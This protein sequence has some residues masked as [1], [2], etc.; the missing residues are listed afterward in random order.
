MRVV[1]GTYTGDG[2]DNKAITGVGF[3]PDLVIVKGVA[4]GNAYFKITQHGTNESILIRGDTSVFTDGIKTLTSDGFTVGLSTVINAS[5]ATYHY[6]AVK[7]DGNGDFK[8]GTYIGN[9]LDGKTVT[10]L[11]FSPAFVLVKSNS[12][13]VGAMKFSGQVNSG[14]QFNGADRSDLIVSLDADGFTVND[15]SGSGANLVNVNAVP[16][17]WFAFKAVAGGC[18]VF[19]YTGDGLD[20]RSITTPGF[21][22]LFVLLRSRDGGTP[23]H[24][25]SSQTGDASQDWESAPGANAIQG[26][27][28]NG[29]QIGS[30]GDVNFNSGVIYA[31]AIKDNPL[32]TSSF[33]PKISFF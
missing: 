33:I 19:S 8:T 4:I 22:P 29:F 15:G 23:R 11:G 9:A 6:L 12:N 26:F 1:T 7:D 13:I 25:F 5:G 2:I 16:H 14:M 30:D 21:Q 20:N 32:V 10:G 27:E 18:S 17:Y 24:R 31:L 3:L 28:T